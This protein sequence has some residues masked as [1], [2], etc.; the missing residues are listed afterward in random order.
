MQVLQCCIQVIQMYTSHNA[1][2]VNAVICVTGI[3]LFEGMKGILVI[4]EQ[5]LLPVIY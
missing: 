5:P 4:V 2:P 1:V 3:Q